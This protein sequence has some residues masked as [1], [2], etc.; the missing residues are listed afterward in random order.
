MSDNQCKIVMGCN[1]D[2]VR[3][4]GCGRVLN[5]VVYKELTPA[6]C[7]CDWVWEEGKLIAASHKEI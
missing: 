3:C 1:G 7:G 5:G 6:P 4:G 2:Q